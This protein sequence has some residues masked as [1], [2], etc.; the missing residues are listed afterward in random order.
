[1]TWHRSGKQVFAEG[2]R[3]PTPLLG[4]LEMPRWMTRQADASPI[5]ETR[6]QLSV[7]LRTSYHA[8]RSLLPGGSCCTSS[9]GYP[10]SVVVETFEGVHKGA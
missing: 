7:V 10:E 3:I 5:G 1:M 4:L 2:S 8:P 6:G 9:S